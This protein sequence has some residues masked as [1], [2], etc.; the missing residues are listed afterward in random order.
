MQRRSGQ[1]LTFS[2]LAPLSLENSLPLWSGFG[3]RVTTAPGEMRSKYANL[4]IVH[5]VFSA[6]II[7]SGYQVLDMRRRILP[8]LVGITAPL[9]GPGRGN[10]VSEIDSG[11]HGLDLLR[12]ICTAKFFY[13]A[14]R[15][16]LI[17]T[18]MRRPLALSNTIGAF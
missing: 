3:V 7:C 1:I 16:E 15:L 8:I 11:E 18:I 14:R 5:P 10:E 4:G 6:Q 9:W 12:V 13:G 2:S 17:C